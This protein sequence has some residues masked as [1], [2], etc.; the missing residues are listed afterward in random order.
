ML[1]LKLRPDPLDIRALL[2][3]AVSE[4]LDLLVLPCINALTRLFDFHYLPTL[5][6]DPDA[7]RSPAC[8]QH[9]QRYDYAGDYRNDLACSVSL[10][11]SHPLCSPY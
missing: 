11:R 7:I 3:H 6:G 9:K 1:L 4:D 8:G 5:I 2:C 10:R